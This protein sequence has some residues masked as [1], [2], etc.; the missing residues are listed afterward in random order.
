M[1][2]FLAAQGLVLLPFGYFIAGVGAFGG[3]E[4]VPGAFSFYR[5]QLRP[6][7]HPFADFRLLRIRQVLVIS[8]C[9]KP[10]LSLQLTKRVP[11]GAKRLKGLPLF[12]RQLIPH[13]SAD[14]RNHRGGQ[15]RG[16]RVGSS[17]RGRCMS[18]VC[19]YGKRTGDPKPR[20]KSHCVERT[21]AVE[22]FSPARAAKGSG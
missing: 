9:S 8:D 21:Q 6:L 19:A 12:R 7:N 22:L 3:G 14:H 20:E 13:W 16:S 10:F 5:S 2:L 17:G 15:C 4:V 11:S 1:L 18:A